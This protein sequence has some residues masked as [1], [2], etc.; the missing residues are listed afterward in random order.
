MSFGATFSSFIV[1]AKHCFQLVFHFRT[2]ALVYIIFVF[3]GTP[4]FFPLWVKMS[5][6]VFSL[7]LLWVIGVGTLKIGG[8]RFGDFEGEPSM[9]RYWLLVPLF[10]LVFT[11]VIPFL[12]WGEA[13][14]G[15]DTG[16]Y[17]K[18]FEDYYQSLVSSGSLDSQVFSPASF[19]ASLLM[20]F[21]WQPP[22]LLSVFYI[23][24]SVSVGLGVYIVTYEY[25]QSFRSAFFSFFLFSISYT[26]FLAFWWFYWR[27][28][29]AMS[30]TLVAL[31]LLKRGSWLIIPVAG[32]VGA[33]HP[34]SFL[35]LGLAL[36]FNFIIAGGNRRYLF[37]SGLGIILVAFSVNWRELVGYLPLYTK[38]YG[39]IQGVP[40]YKAQE[41]T[42]QF[43]TFDHYLTFSFMYL[44]FIILGV[45]SF[46]RRRVF[47]VLFLYFLIALSI[48]LLHLVFH[49]RFIILFDFVAVIFAGVAM[50]DFVKWFL[51]IPYGRVALFL[52]F[53]GIIFFSF[54]QSYTAKPMITS[55]EL[56]EIK[57]L[58]TIAEDDAY[59][60]AL[61]SYYSPWLYGYSHR[62]TIAPG[63]FDHNKWSLEEWQ[64]FWST[65]D[66]GVRKELLDRYDAP[67]YIF[68]GDKLA[69]MDFSRDP[70]FQKISNRIWKYLK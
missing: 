65:S 58:D 62:R 52:F 1:R 46:L 5:Y 23:F 2:L 42:G 57:S 33:F 6:W 38:Q 35:P 53:L 48:V 41:L 45:L 19:F 29:L 20:F 24:L 37:L 26:Q 51:H 7:F 43:I 67:I 34:L 8:A 55:R 25:T 61:S 36:F 50:S 27:M 30:F 32:L 11:R 14:L 18:Q 59:V 49:N 4:S 21:G 10:I 60:M 54:F 28:M 13:P 63:Y 68:V 70:Q 22:W 66:P 16:I 40:A 31:Y 3:L 56:S 15:Y 9:S 69:Y 47:H 39:F 17:L 44:P 64:R 12:Q